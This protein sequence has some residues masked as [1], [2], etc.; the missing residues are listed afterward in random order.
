MK[1][2]GYQYVMQTDDDSFLL[3]PFLQ[4]LLKHMELGDIYMAS[5]FIQKDDP[6]VMWGLAE[7]AKY[8]VMTEFIIPTT[9]FDHCSPRN[10]NGVYSRWVLV[11][12]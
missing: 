6:A 12:V 5:H 1:G 4:N 2:F 7:L 11:K 3:E 9:L 8:F 10:I